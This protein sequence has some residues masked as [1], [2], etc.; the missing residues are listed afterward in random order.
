M[1]QDFLG[2]H[3]LMQEQYLSFMDRIFF[4]K[5]YSEYNERFSRAKHIR[6]HDSLYFFLRL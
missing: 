2:F 4:V 1:F 3:V 5:A 6:E